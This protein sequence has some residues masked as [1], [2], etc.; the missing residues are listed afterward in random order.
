MNTI[1]CLV[2]GAA[3]F[4]G[5]T[6]VDELI[7]KNCEVV[8]IDDESANNENFFWNSRAKNYKFSILDYNSIE[9]LFENIDYV[10]HLGAESR[11]V[12]AIERPKETYDVNIIGTHNVL[13][14]SWVHQVKRVV[15]SS[16]SSVYGLNPTPNSELDREDCLNPYSISKLASEKICKIFT[17]SYKLPI[18]IL[19]YF[20]VFGERASSN[21]IYAPVSSIFLRQKKA[22]LPLTVVGDGENRRDFV[23]VKDVVKANFDFCFLEQKSSFNDVFN[24]GSSRNISILK[25]AKLISPDIK[26][27]P[28]R[29]GEAKTT[30]ADIKKINS[31]IKWLPSLLIEDW[32]KK[33]L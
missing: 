30:L 5:S 4:I 16:T 6:I 24:V 27:I 31:T 14:A 23:Y 7:L 12:N 22:N 17:T 21:G 15:F 2:T 20:N 8:A 11:I 19:R 9:P 13:N 29:I 10:F 26:F 28:P 25:L 32:V 18:T 1:K 3:G 33:F